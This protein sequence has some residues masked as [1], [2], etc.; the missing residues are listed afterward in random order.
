MINSNFPHLTARFFS[1]K[2]Q[3]PAFL[4]SEVILKNALAWSKT[5]RFF[6]GKTREYMGRV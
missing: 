5:G 4:H 6:C 2:R 3:N 1:L